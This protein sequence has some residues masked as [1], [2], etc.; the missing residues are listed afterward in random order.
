MCLP[1]IVKFLKIFAENCLF[2]QDKMDKVFCL[3]T[4]FLCTYS[5]LILPK[6]TQA[7]FSTAAELR[8]LGRFQLGPVAVLN[9][10]MGLLIDYLCV[11]E[12]EVKGHLC[13]C[14]LLCCPLAGQGDRNHLKKATSG[15]RNDGL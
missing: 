15:V 10:K 12:T 14:I 2:L 4:W 3:K 11:N 9:L 1:H 13:S 7:F 8:N 6:T 5:F